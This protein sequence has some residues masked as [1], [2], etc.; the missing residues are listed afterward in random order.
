MT[1]R[2]KMKK[3]AVWRC[4]I[5]LIR[6]VRVR[7]YSRADRLLLM[8]A[9][10]NHGSDIRRTGNDPEPSFRLAQEFAPYDWKDVY[11]NRNANA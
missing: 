1:E 10:L 5:A 3:E 8:T 7:L 11:R 9:A 6:A 2:F 4:F